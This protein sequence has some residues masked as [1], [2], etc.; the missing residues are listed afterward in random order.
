MFH[1]VNGRWVEGAGEPFTSVNPATGETVARVRSAGRPEIEA[2]F[3]ACQAAQ[4]AWAE[5][6]FTN[7]AEVAQR[8]AQRLENRREELA[9][10]ITSEVGK[11]RWEAAQE[12]DAMVRKVEFSIEA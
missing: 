11:P 10:L 8:F 7:R 9:D 12:V 3:A 6:A 4:P 5:L 2:A 1:L